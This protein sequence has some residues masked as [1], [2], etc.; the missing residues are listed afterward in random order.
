METLVKDS[1]FH[2]VD[3]NALVGSQVT[4]LT[5]GLA[6]LDQLLILEERMRRTVAGRTSEREAFTG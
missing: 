2:V 4:L 5:G 1:E 6:E 3:E